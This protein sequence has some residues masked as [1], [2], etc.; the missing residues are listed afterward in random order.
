M[1]MHKLRI[2]SLKLKYPIV[3][4]GMGVGV[5]MADL[6][7]AMSNNG[8][9]GTIAASGLTPEELRLTIRQFHTLSS[10]PL[11][12]NIMVAVKEFRSLVQVCLEENVNL[13]IIGAGFSKDIF[14]W[15][16][17]WAIDHD[18]PE[19][20]VAVLISE[21]KAAR[22]FKK[23]GAAA[24]IFEGGADAAG[25][26]GNQKNW[27]E[28][29]PS[30]RETVGPDFPVIVAGGILNGE[31]IWEAINLY[32]ASGV[33]MGIRWAL[34]WPTFAGKY[35]KVSLRWAWAQLSAN[36][37]DVIVLGDT[38]EHGVKTVGSPVGFPGRFRAN[39][40]TQRL[41]AIGCVGS[42][43]DRLDTC[44]RGCLSSCEFRDLKNEQGRRYTISFCIY[45]RLI[46]AI[47]GDVSWGCV[48]TSR[49]VIEIEGIEHTETVLR[50]L[51]ERY[52]AKEKSM[53]NC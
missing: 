31:D 10:G 8:M 46:A 37:E 12:V 14:E 19:V 9:L 18:L 29:I 26:L 49:R 53:L 25:H 13:I 45:R 34:T 51:I 3:L 4:G 22:L 15:T 42:S 17:A 2:G 47:R 40:L 16:R 24:V 33:Q 52:D 39:L 20:L 7:A 41:Q 38:D 32:G 27:K 28:V 1:S 11:A 6:A 48:F 50:S 44:Q 36:Q 35:S 30:I 21:A 43:A 23:L 5:S